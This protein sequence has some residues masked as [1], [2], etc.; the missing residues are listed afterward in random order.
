MTAFYLGSKHWKPAILQDLV[1]LQ[2]G[3]DITKAE[4][5]DGEVPVISSSGPSSWHSEAMVE[6]PG[7]VIGRKGSLGTVHYSENAYW[8]HDTTLWSKSLNGNNPRFVYYALKCLGL[9]RFNVGG[10]NPT[11][12]RNHIHS[13]PIYLADR[14]TQ[15]NVASW[16]VAYDDLIENNRRRITLLE[17][18]ARMLY[19]EWF[20]HFRFPGH[21]HVNITDGLPEGW[22]RVSASEAF[23]VNPPTPRD[24]DGI[25]T[26]VPMA[27]LSEVGMVIDQAP[28]E[29]RQESTSVRFQNGDTLFARITPCLENGKTGF[30]QFLADGEVACG[31]TEFIVLRERRVS[32]FYVYLT[33]REPAFRENAVRSMIGSSGRQRVQSSC[34]DRYFVA[35]PPETL[36]TIFDD[37]VGGMFKQVANLDNQNRK[38]AQARDLLLP[39]LMNGEIVV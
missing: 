36:R 26:Y 37:S 12:N 19:R 33:A 1:F 14:K 28:L 18:A 27:S 4:Q 21:E 39:R 22:E 3:F 6:G 13:L 29:G 35:V 23:E 24:D 5:K 9:E 31:S 38:L 11:L 20:V 17:E 2:R 32:R 15:D 25:I 10:A 16:L 7:V 8:P 30:V 34:F